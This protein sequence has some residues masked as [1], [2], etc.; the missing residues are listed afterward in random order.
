MT[1]NS[2]RQ[3]NSRESSPLREAC[4]KNNT[5]PLYVHSRL[6]YR[7]EGESIPQLREGF[8]EEA[9]CELGCKGKF[10]FRHVI[11]KDDGTIQV[12]RITYSEGQDAFGGI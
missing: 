2:I 6:K 3:Q 8:P 4:I 9:A 12:E 1:Q 11:S 5:I 7:D 10:A